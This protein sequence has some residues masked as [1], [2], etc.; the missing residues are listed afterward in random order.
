MRTGHDFENIHPTRP[1][2]TPQ[3]ANCVP[4][5]FDGSLLQIMPWPG[6][7]DM[8]KHDLQAIY[9]YLTAIPCIDTV[10][11]DQPHLRNTCPK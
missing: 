7:K 6:Y 5:P 9:E 2:N 3:T 4:F 11:K 10:V 1:A 8:T